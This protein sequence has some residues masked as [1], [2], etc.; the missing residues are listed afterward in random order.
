MLDVNGHTI[1]IGDR[2]RFVGDTMTGIVVCSIDTG[3][4]T[5]DDPIEQWGYLGSGV[6]VHTKEAGLIHVTESAH[7]VLVDQISN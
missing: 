3:E 1:A 5:P 2:V 4:G 7:L 6:M